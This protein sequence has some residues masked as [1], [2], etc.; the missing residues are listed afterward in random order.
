MV[1]YLPV[2]QTTRRVASRKRRQRGQALEN[3]LIGE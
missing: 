2:S 3:W 1:G